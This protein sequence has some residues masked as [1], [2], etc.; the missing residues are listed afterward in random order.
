MRM[1]VFENFQQQK[2]TNDNNKKN[3]VK[4]NTHGTR[5]RPETRTPVLSLFEFN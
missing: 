5:V 3:E 4:P 2:K 1:D